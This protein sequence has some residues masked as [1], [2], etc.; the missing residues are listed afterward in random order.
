[1]KKAT[2]SSYILI[3]A[4]LWGC[5]AVFYRGLSALGFSAL[6]VVFLRTA[7]AALMTGVYLSVCRRSEFRIRL[8]DLWMFIG[9]GIVSLAFFNVCY[10]RAMDEISPSVAAVLLYTA[11]IFVIFLSAVLFRE[12]LTAIKLIGTAIAFVGCILVTGALTGA[13][14]TGKGLF[15]GLGSGIGYALYTIFGV[16]ALRRYDSWCISFYTFVF[17][18][19]CIFF[20]CDAG[21]MVQTFCAQPI[22][23]LLYTVGIGF[24]ACILPYVFY[25]KGLSHVEAGRAAVMATLEPV[26]AVVVGVTV[27]GD[28]LTPDKLLGMVCVIGSIVFINTFDRSM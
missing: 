20:L 22:P 19:V 24:F 17:A 18:A 26:V 27:L 5:I 8:R 7:T 25:T 11:P 4:A 2:A 21:A 3:A 15:F 16:Y 10:F 12:R 28:V 23:A 13:S 9:T 14:V 6:Q 1:M